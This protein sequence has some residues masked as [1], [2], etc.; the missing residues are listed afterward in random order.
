MIWGLESP[1]SV[2]QTGRLEV[3]VRVDFAVLSPNSAGQQNGNA[4]RVSMVQS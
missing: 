4:D 1:K 3:E 2:G